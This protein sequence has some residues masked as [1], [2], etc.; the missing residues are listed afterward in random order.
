MEEEDFVTG[1]DNTE[2]ENEKNT[3]MAGSE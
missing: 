1:G 2:V 3:G